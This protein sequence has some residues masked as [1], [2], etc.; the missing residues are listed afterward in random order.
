MGS[1]ARRS[2]RIALVA[3]AAAMLPLNSAAAH[4]LAPP[5]LREMLRIQGYKVPAP[6]GTEVA[7]ELTLIV[8]GQQ[9]RFAA[10]EWRVFAFFDTA[11]QTPAPEP[12]Q[13]LVQ[14]ERPILHNITAARP[15]QRIT[16]LAERRP[17]S[18][19]LFALAVDLC[20]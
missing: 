13:L 7:R 2:R 12:P 5:P 20:P 19:D 10:T 8:L 1:H 11:G 14:G 15:D 6:A 16:I 18:S 3:L 17:G 4:N 9:V